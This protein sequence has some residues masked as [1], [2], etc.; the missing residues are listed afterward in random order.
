[1]RDSKRIEKFP[2]GDVRIPPSKSLAH[3]A[4]ICAWLAS[5]SAQRE[6]MLS[7]LHDSDDIAATLAGVRALGANWIRQNG[8][9][10]MLP[11]QQTED[12]VIDCNE[13]G[14]TLRFLLPLA[15]LEEKERIFTGRGRLMERPLDIYADLFAE[16]GVLFVREGD[17]IRLKG[18]LKSGVYI[19]PGDV[20]SQFVS[21][22]LF[23]LPMLAGDS[24]IRLTTE[25]ESRAYVDMTVDM[26]RRFG[27][28]AEMPDAYTYRIAGGQRYRPAEYTV[29]ADYSQAAFFLAAAALGRP[30]VCRG[31][32]RESLQGDR[33]ILEILAEMGANLQWRTDGSLAVSAERLRAVTVDARAIPDLMPPVA[34]LC[35]YCEGES[36]IVNAGRLRIKESDRLAALAK[37][38]TALGVRLEETVDSLTI[39][40]AESLPGGAVD[41]HGDHRIAMAM[42]VAAIG[43]TGEVRLTGAESVRKSYPNFWKDF[44]KEARA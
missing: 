8:V 15:A 19:L 41:A 16:A 17:R 21:G 40:G 18:P 43:C 24:E 42:A 25:L 33:A 30:V 28:S 35:S 11:A 9:V 29:E 12:S 27:V 44:E 1:M 32:S 31:L 34:V 37:E 4:V 39:Q 7:N 13:S 3:R 10:R 6:S 5:R 2:A 23:A 14:S 20:S 36:R 26:M 22:L 38:L